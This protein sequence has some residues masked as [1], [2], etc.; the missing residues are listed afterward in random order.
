MGVYTS[1]QTKKG[2]LTSIFELGAWF[3]CM[4]SGFLAE[5]LSRKISILVSTAVFIVGVVVQATAVTGSGSSSILG[6]RFI[7]GKQHPSRGLFR[8]LTYNSARHG[9][10][11]TQYDSPNVQC[12]GCSSR[13]QR[14]PGRSTAARHHG[15]LLLNLSDGDL[16]LTSH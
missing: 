12:R 4:Y 16:P 6:G 14:C 11:C 8:A 3:G 13:G 10:W 2:W 9:R 7:T 5:I 1:D 15:K